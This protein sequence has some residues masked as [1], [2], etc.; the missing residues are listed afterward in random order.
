M[1]TTSDIK[2]GFQM[3]RDF[4]MA[5]GVAKFNL[6]ETINS[7]ENVFQDN[8][9][10]V[11]FRFGLISEEVAELSEAIES[12]DFV[13]VRDAIA[14]I[15]YVIYG[16]CDCLHINADDHKD[17]SVPT[18]SNLILK[19]AGYNEAYNR[20]NEAIIL[21]DFTSLRANL[22]LLLTTIKSLAVRLGIDFDADFLVV[23]NS[24]MS[25]LCDSEEQAIETV[26]DYKSKFAAGKSEYDAPYFVHLPELNK[27]AVKNGGNGPKAGKVLKNKYYKAVKF[28]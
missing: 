25:K 12:D 9:C 23:H 28:V 24:N 22:A 5:F 17:F 27:W 4:N 15:A 6:G 20:V 3:V 11:K 19:L 26:D 16:M 10:L 14:D 18:R 1:D 8:I 21:E 13:E 7:R 2:T